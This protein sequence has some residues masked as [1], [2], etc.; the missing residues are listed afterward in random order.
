MKPS[1]IYIVYRDSDSKWRWRSVA[2]NHR[3]VAAS[4]ESFSSFRAAVRAATQEVA[5]YP[6]GVAVVEVRT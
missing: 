6:L 3:K 4:G 5:L 2:R 1:R